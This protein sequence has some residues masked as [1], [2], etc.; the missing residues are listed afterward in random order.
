MNIENPRASYSPYARSRLI[1]IIEIPLIVGILYFAI[2]SGFTWI[3]QD[4]LETIGVTDG[5]FLASFL[6][7]GFGF[8]VL[9]FTWKILV[10]PL[11]RCL[12]CGKSPLH[13]SPGI[14][15]WIYLK[16]P[17]QSALTRDRAWSETECPDCQT[18]LTFVGS[19]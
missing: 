9:P 17:W 19:A 3:L 12:N 10:H 4:W 13:V 16:S 11:G 5:F 1:R 15:E 14:S 7:F 18:D 2:F 6:T 8:L